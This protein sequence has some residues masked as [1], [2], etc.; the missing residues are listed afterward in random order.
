MNTK[1]LKLPSNRNFGF[2]FFFVFLVASYFLYEI[3]N[4]AYFL[5]SIA[6]SLLFL[7]TALFLPSILTPLN[8]AW[9][10][11]G[12]L[13]G[14]IVSP[15]ILGL[16]F[17]VLITPVAIISKVFGRDE[18]RLKMKDTTTYWIKRDPSGPD[19]ESFKNQF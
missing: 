4:K 17:F 11:F 12:F 13:L 10:K 16:L 8:R 5:I 1:E 18:L 7:S 19:K 9:M 14:R 3:S 15:I 2:L 6:F